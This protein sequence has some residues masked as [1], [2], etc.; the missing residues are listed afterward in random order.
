MNQVRPDRH[1]NEAEVTILQRSADTTQSRW[2]CANGA[3]KGEGIYVPISM[4][5]TCMSTE[6]GLI[7]LSQG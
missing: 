1:E 3:E 6:L 4:S 7:M 5:A 2:K